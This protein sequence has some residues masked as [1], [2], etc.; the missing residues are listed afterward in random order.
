MGGKKDCYNKMH[1]EVDKGVGG[2]GVGNPDTQKEEPRKG[3]TRSETR[4]VGANKKGRK[5]I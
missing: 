4:G 3:G 5:I 2:L 1:S